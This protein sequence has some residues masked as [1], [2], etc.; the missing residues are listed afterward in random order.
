MTFE[1]LVNEGAVLSEHSLQAVTDS[2]ACLAE[3][4]CS[5]TGGRWET[6]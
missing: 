2:H 1:E 6:V 4:V 5:S 3:K